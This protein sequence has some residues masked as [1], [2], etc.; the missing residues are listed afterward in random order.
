MTIEAISPLRR[1]MIEEMTI[2][3][4]SAKT[5][6]QYIRAVK[7][8]AVSSA[9]LPTR[10]GSKISVATNSMLP[11]AVSGFLPRTPP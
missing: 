8:F 6:Q 1:R 3:H 7:N 9:G 11:R 2:R 5:Q 10:Q 4:F